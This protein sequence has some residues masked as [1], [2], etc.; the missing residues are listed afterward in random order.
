MSV[1]NTPYSDHEAS[2]FKPRP[3][4]ART[5][6][7]HAFP[8]AGTGTSAHRTRPVPKST[9]TRTRT[10]GDASTGGTETARRAA[11]TRPMRTF[12]RTWASS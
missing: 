4:A 3:S 2:K 8:P 7:F 12:Q 10:S 5:V 6:A 11:A 1:T 9:I